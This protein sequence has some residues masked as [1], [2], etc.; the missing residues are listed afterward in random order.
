MSSQAVRVIFSHCI[1]CTVHN[2]HV[3]KEGED[4][5][6]QAGGLTLLFNPTAPLSRSVHF[7]NVHVEIEGEDAAPG[8]GARL[9]ARPPP[10]TSKCTFRYRGHTWFNQEEFVF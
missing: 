8:L 6:S 1:K 2:A 7:D 9:L 10:S 3:D 5:A 4:E